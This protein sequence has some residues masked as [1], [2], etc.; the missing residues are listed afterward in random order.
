MRFSFWEQP[1]AHASWFRA[2]KNR[3]SPTQ[4]HS[5]TG[6][7]KAVLINDLVLCTNASIFLVYYPTKYLHIKQK[8]LPFHVVFVITYD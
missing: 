4:T 6:R 3:K 1:R 8:M 5:N 2:F 7:G